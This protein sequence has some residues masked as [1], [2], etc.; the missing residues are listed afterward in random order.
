MILTNVKVYLFTFNC[1]K[2]LLNFLEGTSL[3]SQYCE[4]KIGTYK[5]SCDKGFTL[6]KDE[7]TCKLN[8]PV[9]FFKIFFI[10]IIFFVLIF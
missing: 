7:F 9:S 10:L 2:I 8:N 4:N 6:E 5:C 1:K 3:C